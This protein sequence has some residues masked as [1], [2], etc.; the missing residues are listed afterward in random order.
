M[1]RNKHNYKVTSI[2]KVQNKIGNKRVFAPRGPHLGTQVKLGIWS[3]TSI[4]SCI[5]EDWA[6]FFEEGKKTSM[7]VRTNALAPKFQGKDVTS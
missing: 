5:R 6:I 7:I 3:S 2:I 4:K 1:L